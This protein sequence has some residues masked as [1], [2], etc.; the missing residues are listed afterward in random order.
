MNNAFTVLAGS[1]NPS[2]AVAIARELGVEV[3]ACTLDR[4]PDGEVMVQLN[5]PVRRKEIFIVQP[6]SP[7]V[8]DH[9][10]ELLAKLSIGQIARER[11]SRDAVLVGQTTDHGTVTA[12]S[13]WDGPAE[14][15]SVRPGLS[16][17]YEA[18]FH[19]TDLNRFM[20][21]WDDGHTATEDL[22]KLRLERAIGVIYRP[23]TERV[24]H[25]FRTRLPNQF[26]A[27]LH[28]DETRAVEPLERNEEWETGEV[29]QTFPFA[30]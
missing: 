18:L 21:L 13:D 11:Y 28:F 30:V 24:S 6:T 3:G 23:D 10:I 25:Y 29:L 1:A 26:D 5:E 7:P 12:A 16:G 22:R 4:F 14:R 20:L 19:T 9:L 15:K 27:V 2:L 17:S 8:N